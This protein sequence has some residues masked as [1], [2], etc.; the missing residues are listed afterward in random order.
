MLT[1][2]LL[3][4]PGASWA[5][6][7]GSGD[8]TAKVWRVEGE[9]HRTFIVLFDVSQKAGTRVPFRI[10]PTHGKMIRVYKLRD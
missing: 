9:Q 7:T 5:L 4:Q 10:L 1:M 2:S 3:I 6:A 8:N